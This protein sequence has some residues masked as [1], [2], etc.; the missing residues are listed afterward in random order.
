M[1]L[2]ILLLSLAFAATLSA[3]TPFAPNLKG[4]EA[5]VLDVNG[6]EGEAKKAGVS[7]KELRA[8]LQAQL[9][10]AGLKVV[11]RAKDVPKGA[12]ALPGELMLGITT[13]SGYSSY[14]L[15]LQAYEPMLLDG[16]DHLYVAWTSLTYGFAP[17]EGV[18]QQVRDQV[19]GLGA[20]FVEDYKQ[21]KR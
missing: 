11:G 12:R 15:T 5:L 16:K 9:E 13:H 6:D 7:L 20:S 2:S 8:Q 21:A 4:F 17:K 1:R 3:A 14:A 19:K 18:K 10:K